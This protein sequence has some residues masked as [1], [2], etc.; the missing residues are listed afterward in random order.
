MIP[1]LLLTEVLELLQNFHNL[2]QMF[3]DIIRS[4]VFA[5]NGIPEN[6]KTQ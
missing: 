3:Y 1:V 6:Q 2:Y 5:P 4:K